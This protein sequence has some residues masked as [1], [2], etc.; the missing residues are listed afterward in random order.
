MGTIRDL[1]ASGELGL[2]AADEAHQLIAA[3]AQ[4]A[5][6]AG[7][8]CLAGQITLGPDRARGLDAQGLGAAYVT[9]LRLSV[10]IEGPAGLPCWRAA[11]VEQPAHWLRGAR[12]EE[13][14]ALRQLGLQRAAREATQRALEQLWS[15]PPGTLLCDTSPEPGP[16]G[17]H[18]H[19]PTP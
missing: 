19:A 17:A 9:P 5:L 8:P 11:P 14:E 15:S 2:I 3:R 10:W 6:R 4:P 1:S 13:S 7:A 16:G 12:P 18:E